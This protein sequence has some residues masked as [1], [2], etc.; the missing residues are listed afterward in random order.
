MMLTTT[1]GRAI[2]AVRWIRGI[3][4]IKTVDKFEIPV[5]RVIDALRNE[6][7]S[8]IAVVGRKEDGEL[9]IASSTGTRE[10]IDLFEAAVEEI[11]SGKFGD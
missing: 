4:M 6:E 5:Q 11:N 8:S 3:E 9:Y 10:A 1:H 2:A 7:F